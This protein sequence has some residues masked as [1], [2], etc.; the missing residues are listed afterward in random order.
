MTVE[1][2]FKLDELVSFS[3]SGGGSGGGQLDILIGWVVF[4]LPFLKVF[5]TAMPVVFLYAQLDSDA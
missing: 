1:F 2:S 3:Y 5:R 4:L